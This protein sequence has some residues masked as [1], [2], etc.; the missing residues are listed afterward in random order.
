[1]KEK[2]SDFY[3][4]IEKDFG[5]VIDLE[6]QKQ[7]EK[8]LVIEKDFVMVRSKQKVKDLVI[9]KDFGKVRQNYLDLRKEKYLVTEKD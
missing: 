3:W 4:E 9:A 8:D 7:K 1:M 6:R 2:H 5:M